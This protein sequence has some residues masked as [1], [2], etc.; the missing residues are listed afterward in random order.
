[1]L[2]VN[3]A[4]KRR[5]M[6]PLQRTV[7]LTILLLGLIAL[8]LASAYSSSIPAFIGLGLTFWG[9]IL[10]YIETEEYTRISILDATA[11]SLLT[12]LDLAL[13]ELDYKGKAIYLPPKYLNS[14][15]TAKAYVPKL[16]TGVLPAPEQTQRLEA[17]A[18]PRNAQG[19]LITPPGAELTKLFEKTL[20]TSFTK[21]NLDELQ[22]T[23]PKLLIEDLE[24]ATDLEIQQAP[25]TTGIPVGQ[26]TAQVETKHDTIR[27][28]FTTL[29]YADTCRT[30]QQLPTIYANIGCPL[31][32]AIA[33]AIAKTTGK[34]TT[35]ETQQI[36]KDGRK[37]ETDYRTLEEEPAWT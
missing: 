20:G 29:A 14:P 13:T 23:L 36:S 8:I 27:V 5:T 32:S 4:N 19:I 31:T 6:L 30:A 11:A 28:H 10:L 2:R 26:T 7:G 34:P 12:T 18:S 9:I 17:Q 25:S 1:M 16:R 15:E 33:C 21:M 24:I 35:I 37:T 3:L 22:Q